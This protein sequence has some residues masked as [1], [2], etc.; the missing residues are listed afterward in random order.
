MLV[1]DRYW[2]ETLPVASEYAQ[3]AGWRSILS[4][5]TSGKGCAGSRCVVD[6]R[7]ANHGWGAWMWAL[8]G[9][10]AE[11]LMSDEQPGSWPFYEPDLHT[12]RLAGNKQRAVARQYRAEY[13]PN[14]ALP[15]FAFHQTD[16][17][18]TI[19]QNEACSQGRCSNHSRVRDFDLLGFRYSLLSSIGSGGLNNVLNMLPARDPQEYRLF[20]QDDLSFVS[21]WLKWTDDNVGLLK[22]TRPIPSI[23]T[24]GLGQADGT[25]MVRS[26]KLTVAGSHLSLHTNRY[27][28]FGSSA[29][30]IP[31]QCSY[32][33]R[34]RGRSTSRCR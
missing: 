34:P 4:Q 26:S 28:V 16:R 31:G 22:L 33:T 7:Q 30:T 10:Y 6:N 5:L 23:A 1:W 15:G 18:P 24:P 29:A 13:C 21:K 12:D 17:D 32:S 19:L 25:I 20:P 2:E 8:G 3:W 27:R 14:D 9:T 11:P